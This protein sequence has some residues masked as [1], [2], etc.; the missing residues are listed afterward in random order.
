MPIERS[1]RAWAPGASDPPKDVHSAPPVGAR[2]NAILDLR[3]AGALTKGGR[4]ICRV[5]PGLSNERAHL[6]SRL[7]GPMVLVDSQLACTLGNLG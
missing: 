1:K 2:D 4:R 3:R 7:E 5:G 6:R